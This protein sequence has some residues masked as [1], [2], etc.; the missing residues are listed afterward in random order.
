[1]PYHKAVNSPLVANRGAWG[2]AV[3]VEG[4]LEQM[5]LSHYSDSDL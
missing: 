4:V 1:M 5:T 2:D 3:L